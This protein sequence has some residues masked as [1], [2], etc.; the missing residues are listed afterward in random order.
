MKKEDL[1]N[2]IGKEV[3]EKLAECKTQEEMKQI[4]AEAGVEPMDDELLDAV[5]GGGPYLQPS[6]VYD[7]FR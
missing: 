1:I 2:S 5:T 4:L 3:K 6:I 7:I